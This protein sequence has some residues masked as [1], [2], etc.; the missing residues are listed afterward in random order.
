M[1]MDDVWVIVPVFNESA[2]VAT[3][4][5]DLK[6]RIPN[7]V[8]ID[9]GSTDE[10]GALAA[11]AG[12][13][14]IRHPVNL[15]QGAALQTG[16]DFVLTRTGAAWV[17]TFDADGQHLVDDAVRMVEEG[18]RARVDVVL[19]SRFR[20]TTHGMPWLRRMVLKSALAFTRL[21]TRLKITDTH[22]GLRALST[23]AAREIRL[24]QPKMAYASELL[25]AI[26]ERHLSYIE[27][28]TSVLYTD[29][30]RSKGQQNLNAINIL[31]DLAMA[32][33][34]PTP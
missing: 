3:V 22:N 6:Q 29:Y 28:P 20:G 5:A 27:V 34:R 4:V 33:L 26:S 7:V 21:T 10:S 32:R 12:A 2:T 24:E 17:V 18:R 1:N 23:H 9:D 11:A 8:C 30:S 13:L 25:S 14:V 16:F 15:G 19:A 31:F